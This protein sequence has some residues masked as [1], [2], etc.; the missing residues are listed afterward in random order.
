M[1]MAFAAPDLEDEFKEMKNAA[2][3][4]ELGI[5]DKKKA[6]LSDGKEDAV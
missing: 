3:E 5:S 4:E 2:I 6:I 1:S